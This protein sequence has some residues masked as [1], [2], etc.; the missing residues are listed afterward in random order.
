[1]DINAAVLAIIIAATL[2]STGA[3]QRQPFAVSNEALAMN[4]SPIAM[5]STSVTPNDVAVD[6][7]PADNQVAL[8]A[9][10]IAVP[11]VEE[12]PEAASDPL[13]NTHLAS[14]EAD[15]IYQQIR[16]KNK[17]VPDY[18]AVLMANAIVYFSQERDLDPF[19][20]TALIERESRY[21]RN[22]VSIHGAKGLGQLMSFHFVNL[23]IKNP[24]NIQ[25]GV[26]GAATYFASL[27]ERWKKKGKGDPQKLAL[28][29]YLEG[30]GA[31]SRKQGAWKPH[32][33]RYINDILKT[34]DGMQSKLDKKETP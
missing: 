14:S 28:A 16:S 22:A 13:S 21:N 34:A 24:F 15:V 10:N 27:M 8:S 32:T 33:D 23:N 1:M 4:T 6:P 2:L 31:I 9:E 30:P 5:V 11:P 29:S 12:A 26:R 17:K 25:D 3:N 20:V 19:V 18:E 7:V